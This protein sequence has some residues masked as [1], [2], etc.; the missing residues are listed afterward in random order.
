MKN[1]PENNINKQPKTLMELAEFVGVSLSTVSRALSNSPLISEKMRNRIQELAKKYKVRVN[2]AAQTLRLQQTKTIGLV[3]LKRDFS[4]DGK[5]DPFMLHLIGS[6]ANSLNHYG[7]D[8]LFIQTI[9]NDS[10][11]PRRY[12]MGS[13]VDGFI[14]ACT[15]H[16]ESAI[17]QLLEME[18]PFVVLGKPGSKHKNKYGYV[19]SDNIKGG[20]LAVTRLVE[21]SCR[22]IAFIGGLKTN[23]EV[24]DRL[25]G[26]KSALK[27]NN[28]KY[29][30]EL[31]TF[32][33]YTGKSGVQCMEEL[34]ETNINID[35]VFINSDVMALSAISVLSKRGLSVPEDIQI[36]GFD[37]IPLSAYSKPALT[38]V[39]QDIIKTGELLVHHIIKRIKDKKIVSTVLPVELV[40]RESSL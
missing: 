21:N 16:Q 19:I 39:K 10:D 9:D 4:E 15:A 2:S 36:I 37:D 6:I 1:K 33:D 24:K 34:L 23:I 11:W 30:T 40:V 3:T 31:V 32:G 35:G 26:Y 25:R 7:Y 28:I 18:A 17:N 20:E 13:R 14:L 29:E 8:L 22:K 12:F 38:T 27:K 5:T